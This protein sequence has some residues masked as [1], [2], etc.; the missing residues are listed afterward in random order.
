MRPSYG[1]IS[2]A[3][4]VFIRRPIDVPVTGQ[5]RC[6]SRHPSSDN[7]LAEDERVQPSSAAP[8]QI[9]ERDARRAVVAF[10]SLVV[11]VAV[12]SAAVLARVSWSVSAYSGGITSGAKLSRMK[13]DHEA[14]IG[15]APGNDVSTG[16][17]G[18]SE[19]GDFSLR[20]FTH[21]LTASRS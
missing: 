1:S 9:V 20:L 13:G 21:L 7:G 5:G 10:L 16:E 14:T 4:P 8:P 17:F 18:V 15:T 3:A 11:V 6:P 2:S 12:V 19:V